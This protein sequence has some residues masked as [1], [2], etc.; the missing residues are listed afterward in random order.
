MLYDNA[1][2]AV[3]YLEGYQAT[4]ETQF[5]RVARDILEYVVREMTAPVGGF[6]SATDADSSNPEGEREEGWFFTWTPAEIVA[7]LGEA[8]ARK[9]QAYYGVTERGNFEGRNIFNV[10]RSLEE[11]GTMLGIAPAR[12]AADLAR[13]RQRL[14]E[15]RAR[16]PAPLRDDKI[17]AAWNGLMISAMA[18][19]GFV[20]GEPEFTESAT[21]AAEFVL[22]RMSVDGRL[23]RSYMDGRARHDA[24]LDDYSFLAAG[25]LD[26]FEVTGDPRWLREAIRLHAVLDEHYA[27]AAGGY[28]MT[29]AD[30]ETMIAKEKPGYDG[31]E[32]SDRVV[33]DAAGDRVRAR[34]P[35]GSRRRYLGFPRRCRT[36][37]RD[38]A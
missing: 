6:Y 32:P 17:L 34:V 22:G 7:V 8:E 33:G 9:V 15:A 27:D 30:H 18:R 10:T 35:P 26:L 13:S 2:L 37:L 29:S 19:G 24:Y 3:S 4:G 25:L 21:R 31:A 11:V 12:L 38:T 16:R 5:A 14:Y 36:V 28:F 23:R 1:L 20:L